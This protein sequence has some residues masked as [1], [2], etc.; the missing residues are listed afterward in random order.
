MSKVI[1]PDGETRRFLYGAQVQEEDGV[2]FVEIGAPFDKSIVDQFGGRIA[3]TP[4]P[5]AP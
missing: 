4:A 3:A 5:E 2:K 1:L